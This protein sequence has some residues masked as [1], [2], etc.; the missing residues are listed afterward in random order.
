[1][2]INR[3]NSLFGSADGRRHIRELDVDL[4]NLKPRD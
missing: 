4:P 3:R 1:M 2:K